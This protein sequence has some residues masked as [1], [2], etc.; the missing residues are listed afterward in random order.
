MWSVL[1]LEGR[2][3]SESEQR[4]GNI[5][6]HGQVDESSCLMP[7]KGESDV[8]RAGPIDG[9]IVAGG[10][11][12]EE[13]LGIS[14]GEVLDAKIVNRKREGCRFGGMTPET[15]SVRDRGV[16]VG[17]EMGAKLFIARLK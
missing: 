8:G 12:I 1:G 14:F 17:G 5:V 11:G 10:E 4:F 13:M 15:W 9:E 3:V 7:V 2:R 6:G 16:T